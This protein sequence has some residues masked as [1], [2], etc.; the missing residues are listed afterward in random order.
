MTLVHDFGD[1]RAILD[2]GALVMADKLSNGAW[3]P[4]GE[5]AR[6]GVELETLN[7]LVKSREGTTVT[8]TAP[9]GSVTEYEDP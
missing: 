3:E 7:A 6:P 4:S 9:D 1:G 2:I 8:V 5:P